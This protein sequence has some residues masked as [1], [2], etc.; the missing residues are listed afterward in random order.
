MQQPPRYD[1][2]NDNDADADDG[3]AIWQSPAKSQEKRTEPK[4]K[5]KH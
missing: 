3:V 2:D 4:N 5:T 1:D